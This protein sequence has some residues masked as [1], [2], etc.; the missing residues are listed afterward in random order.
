MSISKNINT[1][2]IKFK[3]KFL[4][5]SESLQH[6]MMNMLAY[7]SSIFNQWFKVN[8]VFVHTQSKTLLN[9]NKNGIA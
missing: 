1:E 8:V 4:T 5:F 3:R 6:F 7:I 2:E 9:S